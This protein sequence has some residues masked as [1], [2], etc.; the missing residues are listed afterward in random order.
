MFN[1][2]LIRKETMMYYRRFSPAG[3]W[4]LEEDMSSQLQFPCGTMFI[5]SGGLNSSKMRCWIIKLK[6]CLHTPSLENYAGK[7]LLSSEFSHIS[8][9]KKIT[10]KV[11]A[12]SNKYILSL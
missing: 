4:V 7:K 5:I 1:F 9:G 6:S 12:F 2:P 11:D 3:N 8:D 10:G